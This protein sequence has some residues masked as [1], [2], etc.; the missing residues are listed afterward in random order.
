MELTIKRHKISL[1]GNL[2]S[3]FIFRIYDLKDCIHF[4]IDLLKYRSGKVFW[5][6]N[7]K[8]WD[9]NWKKFIS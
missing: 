4:V 9:S 8:T 5:I 7:R 1:Y 6:D 2:K 3:G